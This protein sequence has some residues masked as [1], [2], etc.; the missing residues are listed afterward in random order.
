M[1][2]GFWRFCRDARV[3][4]GHDEYFENIEKTVMAGPRRAIRAL[5]ALVGSLSEAASA[6][7][8]I[9]GRHG[10]H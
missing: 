2:S 6:S 1:M 3:K 7:P 9:S 5:R 4:P 10:R 8:A